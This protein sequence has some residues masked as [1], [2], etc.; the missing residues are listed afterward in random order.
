ML[1]NHAEP[2]FQKVTFWEFPKQQE[3]FT[4]QEL[5]VL[6]QIRVTWEWCQE[7]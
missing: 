5:W 7:F 6:K 1:I 4:R 2:V 3:V